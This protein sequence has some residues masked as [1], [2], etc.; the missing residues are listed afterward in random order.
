MNL[1]KRISNTS[2]SIPVKNSVWL[3]TPR[4]KVSSFLHLYQTALMTRSSKSLMTS[5]ISVLL[6]GN[7]HS[8]DLGTDKRI[9]DEQALMTSFSKW[10]LTN[11][12]L[13]LCTKLKRSQL[14]CPTTK[15]RLYI[16]GRI[17]TQKAF[18]SSAYD[19]SSWHHMEKQSYEH[20]CSRASQLL[21]HASPPLITLLSIAGSRTVNERWTKTHIQWD[22]HMWPSGM[23]LWN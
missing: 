15:L 23:A 5:L 8:H 12:Q 4:K 21:V 19:V 16:K 17:S 10:L 14:M 7:K 6:S 1:W 22:D 18:I 9:T 11:R 20:W 3:L 2:L 13:I